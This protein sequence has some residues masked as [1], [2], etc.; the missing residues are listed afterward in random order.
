MS[1]LFFALGLLFGFLLTMLLYLRKQT[2][3]FRQFLD[4]VLQSESEKDTK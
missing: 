2:L 4:L 3:E 1:L